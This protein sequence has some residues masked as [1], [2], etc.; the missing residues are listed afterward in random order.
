MTDKTGTIE[1][2]VESGEW[3][4]SGNIYFTTLKYSGD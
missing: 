1:R 3:G 4:L 2:I